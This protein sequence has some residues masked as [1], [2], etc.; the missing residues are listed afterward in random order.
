MIICHYLY[1]IQAGIFLGRIILKIRM[2][3]T[4]RLLSVRF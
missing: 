2:N 1:R 3:L 4:D